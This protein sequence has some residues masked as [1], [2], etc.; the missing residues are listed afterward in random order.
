MKKFRNTLRENLDLALHEP[1]TPSAIAAKQLG[2]QYVGF[3]RYLDPRTNQVTHIVQDDQL[4]PV[5]AAYRSNDY[6]KNF[7]DDLG[8]F[9][10]SMAPLKTAINDDLTS[11]YSGSLYSDGELDAIKDFTD[12]GFHDINTKL[13]TLPVGIPADQIMPDYGGDTIPKYIGLLDSALAK[14]AAPMEFNAYATVQDI[15]NIAPGAALRF[16]G[17]RSLTLDMGR[18]LNSGTPQ[19][20]TSSKTSYILQIKIP[21]GSAGIYADNFS[22][23]P[24]E[25]EFI[26]PRAATIQVLD[27]PNKIVGSN[28]QYNINKHEIYYFNCQLM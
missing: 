14:G 10:Q 13:A 28:A 18:A 22:A 1:T 27:G 19:T 4:V 3:G 12:T 25:S 16:K 15:S 20:G 9:A 21:A 8:K 23:S 6:K 11:A 7:S 17:F 26:L 2:L 24:G 5:P